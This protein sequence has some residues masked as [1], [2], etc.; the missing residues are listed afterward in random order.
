MKEF[1]EFIGLDELRDRLDYDPETGV[2][3]H[4]K[5]NRHGCA[6]K[7]AGCAFHGY[8]LIGI[9]G[10]HY[11]AH[12]LAWFYVHGAWPQNLID[13]KNG[14]KADNRLINLRE[15]THS[16]NLCNARGRHSSRK[17]VYWD[18]ARSKWKVTV[19]INNSTKNIGR[20]DRFC[21]AVKARAEAEKKI[22]GEFTQSASA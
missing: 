8:V 2:F 22:H 17:G 5:N 7:V 6:G 13:H 1:R 12:R 4:K 3:T 14:N 20:Y 9:C 16:Q 10:K 11:L 19:G 18:R 21:T 15:A